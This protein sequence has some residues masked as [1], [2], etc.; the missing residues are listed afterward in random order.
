MS[1]VTIY[2]F[3]IYDVNSDHMQKSRRWGTREAIE[4]IHGNVLENTASEVDESEVMSDLP[5]LTDRDFIPHPREGFQQ[6]MSA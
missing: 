3:Q 6:R 5:G 4:S 1:R 2:Q